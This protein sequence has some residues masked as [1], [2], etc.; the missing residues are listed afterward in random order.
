MRV[1]PAGLFL[2]ALALTTPSPAQQSSAGQPLAPAAHRKVASDI[3]REVLETLLL[4]VAEDKEFPAPQDPAKGAVVLHLRNPDLS[5]PLVNAAEV[6]LDTG[7]KVLPHDAWNDLIRRNV[8]R[9]DPKTREVYY[10]GLDFDSKIVVGDAY[11]EPP[12]PLQG[13]TFREVYPQAR[14]FVAAWLPGYSEDGKTAVVRARVGPV[15]RLATLTAILRKQGD[16]W[17]VV[18]RKYNVYV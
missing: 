18:W 6:A 1:F 14:G 8:I 17:A 9:R 15:K 4:S 13:K 12:P 5:E 16:R 10:E 3:D 2:V 11:P 7:G